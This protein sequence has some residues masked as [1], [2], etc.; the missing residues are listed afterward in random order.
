MERYIPYTTGEFIS[1]EAR[2]GKIQN[3]IKEGNDMTNAN[4][5]TTEIAE[6]TAGQEFEHSDRKVEAGRVAADHYQAKKEAGVSP[7]DLA[8]A[9]ATIAAAFYAPGD[10]YQDQEGEYQVYNDL[11][12]QQRS[13]L[14]NIVSN[15]VW[16][17]NSAAERLTKLY[18]ELDTA[19]ATFKGSDGEIYEMNRILDQIDR[20]K[21]TQVPNCAEYIGI[22]KGAYLGVRGEDW[23][24]FV[25][26]GKDPKA[27]SKEAVLERIKK[28]RS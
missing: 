20:A 13:A 8:E 26:K 4:A 28:A 18:T 17:L 21:M 25:K 9:V 23:K 3:D 7:D 11:D 5:Q 15:A 19:E 27:Q 16:M 24:P 1:K 10:H 12:F 6:F 2:E 22:V 14:G